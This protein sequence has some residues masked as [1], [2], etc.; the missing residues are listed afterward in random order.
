[1]SIPHAE[2]SSCPT[3]ATHD[4][5]PFCLGAPRSRVALSVHPSFSKGENEVQPTFNFILL[6][7][8]T[9]TLDSSE[10]EGSLHKR[11]VVFRFLNRSKGKVVSDYANKSSACRD[12]AGER[13][14]R[15]RRRC[16]QQRPRAHGG[17][18]R[19]GKPSARRL[20]V[21]YWG[22]LSP[23]LSKLKICSLVPLVAVHPG[24][25]TETHRRNQRLSKQKRSNW[26]I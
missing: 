10:A 14:G 22:A 2:Q 11:T 7:L 17:T 15:G 12:G 19:P 9:K 25:H 4:R 23:N 8:A 1:M 21:I 16:G 13:G 18:I 26:N 3:C 20:W 24:P 6:R 5:S